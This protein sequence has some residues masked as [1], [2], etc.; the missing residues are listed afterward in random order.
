MLKENCACDKSFARA[1]FILVQDTR[2]NTSKAT[3]KRIETRIEIWKKENFGTMLRKFER[4]RELVL[5]GAL[6][7]ATNPWRVR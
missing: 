5:W 3:R 1:N 7:R 2:I 6:G 4:R